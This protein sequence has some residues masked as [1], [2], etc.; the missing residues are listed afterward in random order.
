[1]EVERLGTSLERVPGTVTSRAEEAVVKDN[2]KPE[3]MQ[4]F[5]FRCLRRVERSRGMGEETKMPRFAAA[6]QGKGTLRWNGWGDIK[7]A[8]AFTGCL[9][10][11]HRHMTLKTLRVYVYPHNT[12]LSLG[13]FLH[14]G[15]NP[16]MLSCFLFAIVTDKEGC[17]SRVTPK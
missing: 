5:E 17:S 10:K 12:E 3:S 1:M 4:C 7:N 2:C 14:F 6:S 8:F 15:Q 16:N 11:Q 13:K 9:P